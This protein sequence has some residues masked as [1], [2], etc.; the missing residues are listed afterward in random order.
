MSGDKVINNPQDQ[1]SVESD[2]IHGLCAQLNNEHPNDPEDFVNKFKNHKLDESEGAFDAFVN[3]IEQFTHHLNEVSLLAVQE[4]TTNVLYNDKFVDI[5]MQYCDDAYSAGVSEN[6]S[7]I[8]PDLDSILHLH[9]TSYGIVKS[10]QHSHVDCM[11]SV[12]FDSGA[13]KRLLKQ[14]ALPK[15]INPSQGKKR[16]VTRVTLS[17]IMDREILIKNMTLPEFSSTQRV[18][19]PIRVIIMDNNESLL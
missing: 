3:T 11:L 9:A 2:N 13:D 7:S 18:P 1:E 14:S 4:S 15:G 17:A 8:V 19:G 6:N 12:L 10:M 16:K 5:F